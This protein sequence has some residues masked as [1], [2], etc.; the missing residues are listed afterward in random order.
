[1][2]SSILPTTE[3]IQLEQAWSNI[4]QAMAMTTVVYLELHQ[5][6]PKSPWIASFDQDGYKKDR[7]KVIRLPIVLRLK[8][9]N[10][11]L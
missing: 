3:S 2:P 11:I 5:K 1:L 7:E 4:K 9:S 6:D 10:S 8:K